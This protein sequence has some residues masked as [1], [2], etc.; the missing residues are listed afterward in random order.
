MLLVFS[1][2]MFGQT[3]TYYSSYKEG[4]VLGRLLFTK[5]LNQILLQ[6]EVNG[7]EDKSL[8]FT[9][10]D[11]LRIGLGVHYKWLGLAATIPL[12]RPKNNTGEGKNLDF[13][14]QIILPFLVVEGALFRYNGYS[15]D[16]IQGLPNNSQYEYLEGQ[17]RNIEFRS[18]NTNINYILNHEKYSYRSFKILTEKQEISAGSTILGLYYNFTK[19][20]A[21]SGI[22]PTELKGSFNTNLDISDENYNLFGFS[23]G[24]AYNFVLK[25]DFSI[26]ALLSLGPGY[27]SENKKPFKKS[28]ESES[29]FAFNT[30]FQLGITHQ[31]PEYFYRFLVQI[32]SFNRAVNEMDFRINTLQG[33]VNFQIGKRFNLK[34]KYH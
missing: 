4:K 33:Y 16:R 14:G 32:N 31:G 26:G 11:P 30:E 2:N 29:S 5:K 8:S 20:E 12:S 7:D 21:D 6:E 28:S 1:M 10:D 27:M 9:P 13:Q 3:N 15:I 18:F 17:I 23:V 24:Y 19:L 25:N 34:S 22:I